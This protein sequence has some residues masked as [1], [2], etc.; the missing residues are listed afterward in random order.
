M[1][2]TGGCEGAVACADALFET[3]AKYALQTLVAVVDG[4]VGSRGS[5][6]VFA[7]VDWFVGCWPLEILSSLCQHGLLEPIVCLCIAISDEMT[8]IAS[9]TGVWPVCDWVLPL[10]SVFLVDILG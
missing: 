4:S 2:W 6:E 5:L 10:L 1:A 3:G 7:R 8:R 9:W